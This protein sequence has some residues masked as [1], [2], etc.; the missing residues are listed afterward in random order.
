MLEPIKNLEVL[1]VQLVDLVTQNFSC[2]RMPHGVV[3]QIEHGLAHGYRCFGRCFHAGYAI[4]RENQFSR[5][6][7]GGRSIITGNPIGNAL[8]TSGLP[9]IA[10]KELALDDRDPR[11][12]GTV[13]GL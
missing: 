5:A 2:R 13:R 9:F 3:D 11:T 4:E 12:F 8:T 7:A 10:L 1:L 6:A